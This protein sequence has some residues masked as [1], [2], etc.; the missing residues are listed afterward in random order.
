MKIR[1]L[2]FLLSIL[3]YSNYQAQT[4]NSSSLNSGITP[5]EPLFPSVEIVSRI[6]KICKGQS[7]TLTAYANNLPLDGIYTYTWTD[8][9]N[10]I[11]SNSGENTITVTPDLTK[12]YKVSVFGDGLYSS[13]SSHGFIVTVVNVP[14]TPLSFNDFI[15][16]Q[17][18]CVGGSKTFTIPSPNSAYTYTWYNSSNQVVTNGNPSNIVIDQAGTSLTISNLTSSATFYVTAKNDICESAMSAFNVNLK[19]TPSALS[20]VGPIICP[21]TS[22]TIIASPLYHNPDDSYF[23][24]Y[25]ATGQF[26][27]TGNKFT[28]PILK[29]TTTFQVSMHNGCPN[30]E[31]PKS[32]VTVTVKKET[33]LPV[34]VTALDI[35]AN[36]TAT[37]KVG[38]VVANTTYKWYSD[39]TSKSPVFTGNP[40]SLKLAATTSFWVSATSVATSCESDKILVTAKVLGK[41]VLPL[42]STPAPVCPGT[43]FSLSASTNQSI[44]GSISWLWSNLTSGSTI[45]YKS[46][47][48]YNYSIVSKLKII[49]KTTFSV[50]INNG[51]MAS[52][53]VS[54]TVDVIGKPNPPSLVS[55]D[56][57][58][59]CKGST[60]KLQ[61]KGPATILWYTATGTKITSNI[62][63]DATTQISTLTTP[64]ISVTGTKF[65]AV[66]NNGCLNSDEVI[67]T[68]NLYDAPKGL[69]VNPLIQPVCKGATAII[70]ASSLSDDPNISYVWTLANGTKLPTSGNGSQLVTP[71]ITTNPTSFFV[72]TNSCGVISTVK[73]EAK[74]TFTE[75]AQPVV[76]PEKTICYGEKT[77]LVITNPSPLSNLYTYKWYD[78]TTLISSNTNKQ[79]YET[80]VLTSD[81]EYSVE[82]V[83]NTCSSDVKITKTKVKVNP[84]PDVS[85]LELKV[86]SKICLH[87]LT[88][89]EG[90]EFH[91][92]TASIPGG[93]WSTTTEFADVTPIDGA[94]FGKQKEGIETITYTLVNE[95][96]CVASKSTTAKV[97]GKIRGELVG[98]PICPG[99]R[100]YE[101]TLKNLSDDPFDPLYKVE[102]KNLKW[103]STDV[104]SPS[105]LH[106]VSSSTDY[107]LNNFYYSYSGDYNVLISVNVRGY[108]GTSSIERSIYVN[109]LVPTPQIVADVVPNTTKLK[110]T[111]FDANNYSNVWEKGSQVLGNNLNEVNRPLHDGSVFY[112][113]YTDKKT[114]CTNS[115]GWRAGCEIYYLPERKD[116]DDVESGDKIHN[117]T[118]NSNNSEFKLV[119][120]PN[121]SV[122]KI[123]FESNGY[124]GKAII[125]NAIGAIVKEVT[126]ND[127]LNTY[128]INFI[129]EAKGLYNIKFEGGSKIY[130]TNF[131][132]E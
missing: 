102:N 4:V 17:D 97:L 67:F 106:S 20:L 85:K 23:K 89:P 21:N 54:V 41:P 7:V 33:P 111:N 92:C 110:V 113:T 103:T 131:V 37:F 88:S 38:T 98:G 124:I 70:N 118:N 5:P 52:D 71:A 95:F 73:V 58:Q 10:K 48:G 19:A 108:C 78:G 8:E 56:I 44:V 59:V 122:D 80:P 22:T 51:C 109:P 91:Q 47:M 66:V 60:Q 12:T 50:T 79:T 77:T 6:N 105:R 90:I 9:N 40:Y 127:K 87:G 25:D 36:S 63:Y 72:Q 65:K 39:Q 26:L 129:N 2:I 117:L 68:V 125:T 94:I 104:Q 28:T 128:E 14:N 1:N 55:K 69:F 45:A 82:V 107:S 42:V 27:T 49:A 119:V 16:F 75:T 101:F 34:N 112:C 84:L 74:V 100:H 126:L 43:E 132:I 86:P 120:Y 76:V 62:V 31:G 116:K 29:T 99:G 83:N 24:W 61:V 123:R 64:P 18:V 81:R 30:G 15:D 46:F 96:K 121:P 53:P 115:N 32:N 114:N 3:I 93:T 13:I 35:C 130:T 57:N 11:I